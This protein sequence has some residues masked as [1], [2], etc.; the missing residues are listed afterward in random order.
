MR[1]LG[2]DR[3]DIRRLAN[4]IAVTRKRCRCQVIRNNEQHIHPFVSGVDLGS[5]HQEKPRPQE[6]FQRRNNL[7]HGDPLFSD[8]LTIFQPWFYRCHDD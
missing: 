7:I 5:G 1:S 3:I 2:G 6:Q 8:G 4:R